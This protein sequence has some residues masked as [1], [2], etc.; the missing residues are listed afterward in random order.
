MHRAPGYPRRSQLLHLNAVHSLF[1]PLLLGLPF[2]LSALQQAPNHLDYL[3][4]QLSA[5]L[6][7]GRP[8]AGLAQSAL[9]AA[10]RFQLLHQIADHREPAIA[11][12]KLQK[13][14]N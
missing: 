12:I 4:L 1:R 9:D 8:G 13:M 10:Q 7:V 2:L 11:Q 6:V 5:S 14:L 3:P